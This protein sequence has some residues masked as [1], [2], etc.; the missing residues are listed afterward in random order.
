MSASPNRK[1]RRA[2]EPKTPGLGASMKAIGL[3]DRW[4]GYWANQKTVGRQTL[5]RLLT[6]P[7]STAM[8]V[9]VI[10]IALALPVVMLVAQYR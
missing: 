2:V 3:K 5:Q 9:L 7:A 10:G 6:E 4:H 8:T 1:P